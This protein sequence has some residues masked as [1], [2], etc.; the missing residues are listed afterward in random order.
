[1]SNESVISVYL[2][3]RMLV[4][5]GLGFSSGLPLLLTSSTL[6]VW[7]RQVGV[8]LGSVGLFGLVALPYS[9]KFVWAP[10]MDRVSWPVLG[11]RRGWLL[12]TQVAL[13]AAL[14]AIALAGPQDATASLWP[15]AAAALAAAFVSASQ[16]IVADAY[17]TDIL[18][19]AELGAGAAVFVTGYRVGMILGGAAALVMSDALPWRSVYFVMA[20]CVGVGVTATL[21]GREPAN[22]HAAPATLAD[23]V[24]HPFRAFFTVQGPAHA[25]LVLL[26]IM[27][28]RLPDEA[29]KPMAVALLKDLQFTNSEIGYVQQGFGLT[30]TIVGALLGGVVVARIGLLRSLWLFGV[31]QAVSNFGFLVL[32]MIGRDMT[33]LACVVTIEAFCGGLVTAGFVAFL[34]SC[35]DRR[36][37]ATQYALLSSLMAVG[38][39]LA[40]APTGFVVELAGY[41]WFFLISVLLAAPGLALLP[42]IAGTLRVS[43]AR[44]A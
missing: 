8:D 33:A 40:R 38:G 18:E 31:L 41:P 16:D 39:T 23:A 43:G 24:V 11:R 32:A 22:G 7:M 15:L 13:A 29:V 30:M 27:L 21:L 10:V 12:L 44:A 2:S 6:T 1:M 14:V 25:L 9:L 3:R 19:P 34:M 37:S 26:F 5:L 4:L 17:R 28:F 20:A 35:C 42:A 36:Y